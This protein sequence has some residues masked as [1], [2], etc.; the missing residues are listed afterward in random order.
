MIGRLNSMTQI[1]HETC[2][3]LHC[4]CCNHYTVALEIV[5]LL[6]AINPWV[7]FLMPVSSHF[8]C[9]RPSLVWKILHD[10][11]CNILPV[12]PALMN[13]VTVFHLTYHINALIYLS[14]YYKFVPVHVCWFAMFFSSECSYFELFVD[15]F[16]FPSRTVNTRRSI[17]QYFFFCV[18]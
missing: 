12:V 14:W 13:N 9:I 8:L 16:I 10:K 11:N 15:L 5:Q 7:C 1:P 2:I 18:N 17:N 6:G 4:S 3:T